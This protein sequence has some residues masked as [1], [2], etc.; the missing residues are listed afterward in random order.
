MT[1]DRPGE[2]ELGSGE[3]LLYAHKPSLMGAPWQ[4]R[5]RPDGLA[6][7]V[8]RFDGCVPYDRIR[9]VRLTFRPAT[10]Q[11]RRFV[12]EIWPLDGPKLTIASTS[13]RSLVEQ[14]PQDAAYGAFIRAL[15][16][17]IAAA[18]A[19]ASFEAGSPPL[20]YWPGLVVFVAA[21]LALAALT[22]HAL[23]TGAFAGAAFVGVFLALF[24]WQSGSYFGRN[25]PGRYSP[26]NVP[27]RLVP[28]G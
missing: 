4:F 9:R 21:A 3:V 7:Q 11:S 12:A 22:L 26:E 2:S 13:W 14:A 16:R 15:H 19:R 24:L 5:L 1:Q 25:R 18:D 27:D 8:G 20:L 23:A 17:R 6:W 28:P 10:M